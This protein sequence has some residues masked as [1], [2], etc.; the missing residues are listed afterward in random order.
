MYLERTDKH[1]LCMQFQFKV[2]SNNSGYMLFFII[3]SIGAFSGTLKV[4]S[5]AIPQPRGGPWIQ[6]AG[7]L[8]AYKNA[9]RHQKT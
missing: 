1:A 5:P 2:Y 3:I 8:A 9:L 7:V 4:K 6:I